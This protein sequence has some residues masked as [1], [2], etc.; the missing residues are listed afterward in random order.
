[1]KQ[2]SYM[3]IMITIRTIEML[4]LSIVQHFSSTFTIFIRLTQV[5]ISLDNTHPKM[6][7]IIIQKKSNNTS[8]VL[9]VALVLSRAVAK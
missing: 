4:D 3:L 5:S 1:M 9:R 6:A 7:V 2:I 8:H